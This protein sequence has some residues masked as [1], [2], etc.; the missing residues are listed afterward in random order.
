MKWP[1]GRVCLPMLAAILPKLQ[2][3]F[4]YTA[5]AMWRT[6]WTSVSIGCLAG[7][8]RARAGVEPMAQ[9]R[10]ALSAS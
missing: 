1:R 2:Y 10:R 9:S 7:G 5:Y 4:L 6:R 8:P 3:T